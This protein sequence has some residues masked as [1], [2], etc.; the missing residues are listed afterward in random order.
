VSPNSRRAFILVLL[1]AAAVCLRLGF[2]QM[3]RLQER[4]AANRTAAEARALAPV[5]LPRGAGSAGTLANRR[6]IA[7]GR[8]DHD[9]EFVLRGTSLNGV[10]G[11]T[12]VTPL[13]LPESDTALL[14][15]RGFVPAPDAVT[16]ELD[17]LGEP[18]PREVAGVALPIAS[19]EG[20]PLERDGRTS[21][22]RL[23]LAALRERLPYPLYPVVLRQSPDSTLPRSPR[24]LQPPALDDGPHLTY[25]VQWFLFAGLSAVFAGVVVR[26]TL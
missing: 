1:V 13:R 17:S 12:V 19:G 3:D 26:R 10:P 22:G 25:A 7:E 15:A 11:V 4:R 14:V 9:N 6:V 20:R 24:R 18:G 16:A 2:W 8:Y 21:W 5:R 23:D